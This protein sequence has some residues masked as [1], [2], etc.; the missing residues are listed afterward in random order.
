[1]LKSNKVDLLFIDFMVWLLAACYKV[2]RLYT[3]V[4]KK[5]IKP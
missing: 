3:R 2:K 1:M 5:K 4:I